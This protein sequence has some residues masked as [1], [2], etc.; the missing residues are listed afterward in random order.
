MMKVVVEVLQKVDCD[1]I[2]RVRASRIAQLENY[3]VN[4]IRFA[5]IA[6]SSAMLVHELKNIVDGC[7]GQMTIEVKNPRPRNNL[8]KDII[9]NGGLMPTRPTENPM[10][11]RAGVKL[12]TVFRELIG[13]GQF[14]NPVKYIKVKR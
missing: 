6:Q 12:D 3:T 8:V 11:V 10:V 13:F 9:R 14:S 2:S 7:D 1:L 4:Y 5:L